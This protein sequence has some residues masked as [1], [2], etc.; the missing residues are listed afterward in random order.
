[1]VWLTNN[2]NKKK[3]DSDL[4]SFY[5]DSEESDSYEPTL[6]VP[7]FSNNSSLND[8]EDDDYFFTDSDDSDE[9]VFDLDVG[10]QSDSNSSSDANSE[11]VF[12]SRKINV[13]KDL[14]E[15]NNI[16]NKSFTHSASRDSDSSNLK[17]N[18]SG[19]LV[20]EY[21]DHFLADAPVDNSQYKDSNV[22]LESIETL[23]FPHQD[24]RAAQD[25]LI[26]KIDE[27][28]RKKTNLLVH[29]PTGLGKTAASLSPALTHILKKDNKN[30]T[31][32]FL[33][34]R[35]TQHKI[36]LDTLRKINEKFNLRIVGSSIIGKKHLCLQP[37]V[38]TLPSKDFA[39]FCKL[40]VENGKCE[41]FQN[42]KSGQK[43]L[44]DAQVAL[45]E[46][47]SQDFGVATTENIIECSSESRLC[48]YEMSL[49]LA[50]QAR[51]IV[52][53]Y[54]YMF[55]PNIR[56]GFLKRIN[57]ELKDAIIII[58][59]AHNLS[60]RVK[61]LVSEYLSNI[62]IKRAI[63]EAKKFSQPKIIPFL[64][65]L[66]NIL[67]SYTRALTGEFENRY[68]KNSPETAAAAPVTLNSFDQANSVSSNGSKKNW[69][70]ASSGERYVSKIEFIESIKKFGDYEELVA[71]LTFAGNLIRETQHM[72]Y[73]GAIAKFL[74]SWNLED[75]GFTR[76]I[77]IKK[78]KDKTEM[79]T[80]SY[81]CLD[82]SIIV[83]PV[84]S[85][86]HSTIMMSGT[87]TPTSMYKE[88]FGINSEELTLKS[89]FPQENRLNLIIPKTSTKYELRSQDQYKEIAR[90]LIDVSTQVDGCI[91]IYYP[92]Y[93]LMGEI[94]KYLDTKISKTIFTESPEMSKSE[95]QEFLQNFV[96]YKNRG[97]L[98][99]AVITGSF[100]E[101]V[102]LPG[103]LKAVIII[104]LPLQ[105]PD[106]ETKSLIDYY[107]KKFQK[108]W[109]YGYLFPAFTKTIQAA[110]RCIRSETDRGVIIFLDERYAWNNYYRCFPATWDIKVSALYSDLIGKFFK[111][112]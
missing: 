23:L 80:L 78:L 48:P 27:V 47:K 29:A 50:K 32:Y 39:E 65:E 62:M 95:K 28:I 3:T 61:D 85:S 40:L 17:R 25:V 72:S 37:N 46:L 88:L 79:I 4:N 10:S 34:S 11:F 83:A 45:N 59:E 18:S 71:E 93:Y 103:V 91:A 106:L 105:K 112:N 99:N 35:H 49:L 97:A 9:L 70:D 101:G 107:D 24:I 86:S 84:V 98:L 66:N 69:N 41:F 54:S 8:S 87:F 89:P 110:G 76:I 92:S 102:D 104:G 44:P 73:I 111:K 55:N 82:P 64:E 13:K 51:V 75:T 81:R 16:K 100:A 108:G 94:A 52:T 2:L 1:V 67:E 21:N 63:S 96:S 42:V 38:E 14:V 26:K 22:D 109:D 5:D 19:E 57:K 53:D 33:T 60:G 90:I 68:A 30:M 77:N 7:D 20:E 56:E 58:D 15:K 43:I 31:I 12:K 74:E 36:V 6:D